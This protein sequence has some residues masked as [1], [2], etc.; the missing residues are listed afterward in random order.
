MFAVEI[1]EEIADGVLPRFLVSLRD[2]DNEAD[3]IAEIICKEG[4][5]RLPCEFYFFLIDF[6]FQECCMN[7]FL[8]DCSLCIYPP[9]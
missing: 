2:R 4:R 5:V 8:N 9:L 3:D 1:K 7:F 6:T